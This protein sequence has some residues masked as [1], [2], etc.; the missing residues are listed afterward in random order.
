[1]VVQA[2]LTV[3]QVSLPRESRR[4]RSCGVAFVVLPSR[5][6]AQIAVERLNGSTLGEN[7]LSVEPVDGT[8]QKSVEDKSANSQRR[9][10]WK[11]D[12]ELWQVAVFAKEE[13]VERFRER[14]EDGTS[15]VMTVSMSPHK[16]DARFQAARSAELS[17]E[18]RLV[19]NALAGQPG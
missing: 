15:S 8:L 2:G 17:L 3:S 5:E 19:R 13:S 9:I 1:M 7:M 6:D 16:G 18:K 12:D 14:M 10:R 11:P 4:Q